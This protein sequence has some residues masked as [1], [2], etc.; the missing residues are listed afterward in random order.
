MSFKRSIPSL[1]A[2]VA[3]EA[4]AR[5][6]SFT[7]AAEEL[8]VTQTAISRQVLALEEALDA[9]LFHR[10]HRAVEPTA[11]CNQL[12]LELNRH[13]TGISESVREFGN[14][15]ASGVVTIGATTA[16]AQ[17][18]LL[19]RL[20]QFR[21]TN[22][23]VKFRLTVSDKPFDMVSGDEDL[24]VRYGV[25]PFSDGLVIASCGDLLFPVASPD[26]A[27]SLGVHAA[28]FWQTE[29]NLISTESTLRS[30]YSW[31]DWFRAVG[32][33]QK[34]P[35][36]A[37]TFNQFPGTLYAARAG[38]GIALGWGLLVQTFLE[39]E[40]LVRLGDTCLVAEGMFHVVK[41]NRAPESPAMEALLNWLSEAL[42]ASRTAFVSDKR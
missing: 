20:V 35:R 29:F 12:A 27:Q 42:K 17:L 15:N 41:S 38:Q 1:T 37:L 13:F 10:G 36:A 32:I 34:P 3:L 21:K 7:R 5:H 39:D 9:T 30:W 16:F 2:L 11:Q 19:P 22:P 28:T 31:E 14:A 33:P 18:W 25:S 4:A 24:V 23:E 6:K 26:Y 8:G 40:T